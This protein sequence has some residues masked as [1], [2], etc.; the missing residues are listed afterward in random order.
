M[1]SI[2]FECPFC[3]KKQDYHLFYNLFANIVAKK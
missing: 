1:I 2:K 3:D